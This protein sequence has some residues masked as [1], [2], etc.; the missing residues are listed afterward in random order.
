MHGNTLLF[1]TFAVPLSFIQKQKGM[2]Y[3]FSKY[4]THYRNLTYLGVP[5]I[6]GQ[7]GNLILNFADTLMIGHH[8]TEE[9]AAAA[10]V[11]NMF[12]LVIIFAIGFT[13]AV[14]ALVGTLYGQEKTHRIGELMKSAV[15]ANTC[16][17]VFLSVIM[18]ALYL[19]VHRLGQPEELLP[20]IRPYFLIQLV[21]LPFVCWFNTFRQ[22]TDGITD[23][24]VAMWILVSGNVMNIFG[25]WILI[26]GHLGI[27][28]MGLIGAGLSTMI[29]R[30]VMAIVMAGV[31]FFGRKYRE[32]RKGWRLGHTNRTDFRQIT[33]LG[34]PLALQMGMEAAAFS[35]SSLMV[36]WF[37][38]T[39]LAAH[40]VML[41]ISQLGY[42]IYYGLAAAVAVRISNFMGQRDYTSVRRTATAGI[43][44]VFLLALSTSVP[45]FLCRHIIGDLFTDNA[46]VI[47]MVSMTI[48]PFMI[49]QFGDGMQ[50]N[51]ANAL[52]GIAVVRPL[53]WIAFIAF[54]VVSLPLG[55]FFGVV[56]DYGLLGV[57]YAFPFGLTTAGILYYVYYQKGL[58]RIESS[59]EKR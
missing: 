22:F 31:F 40:Q 24:K 17:A 11:N 54:F 52:R 21:S 14:T 26:Y 47:S 13:Y 56:M 58:K 23:T 49:Y 10:F 32:Y 50:C 7:L 59:T 8:S 37:G 30:I 2:S 16:M 18:T 53:T 29:S 19:N 9:L 28:E 1:R 4:E 25:N 55:Y 3:Q 33:V 44:L 41:T 38:T 45:V 57:W 34:L 36:G 5:I 51:Y 27:P 6:I 43:H 12:T 15:A 46:D 39:S 20:L 42:M 48:V 35:L